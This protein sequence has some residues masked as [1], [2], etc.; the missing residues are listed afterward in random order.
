LVILDAQGISLQD[1]K[2]EDSE[3]A[4]CFPPGG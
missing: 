1:W 4:L 3:R 2:A